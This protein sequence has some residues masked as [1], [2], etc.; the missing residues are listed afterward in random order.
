MTAIYQWR[1][2]ACLDH[3]R[4]YLHATTVSDALT[5]V[6]TALAEAVVHGDGRPEVWRLA[7]ART[8]QLLAMLNVGA[9]SLGEPLP[10]SSVAL[11]QE[12]RTWAVT[13]SAGSSKADHERSLAAAVRTQP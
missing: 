9:A 4:R 5:E 8:T 6:I 11:I 3:N 2:S 7:V 10:P 12:L 1:V 13:M